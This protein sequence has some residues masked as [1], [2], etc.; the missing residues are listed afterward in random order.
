MTAERTVGVHLIANVYNVSPTLLEKMEIGV[1]L[2][3]RIIAELQLNVVSKTGYQFQPMG[4]TYA[5]VL[6]ESHFTIHTYPEYG[7]CFIDIFCCNRNFDSVKAVELLKEC[8]GTAHVVYQ[9][10]VR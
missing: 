6:S 3:E 7:S 8:F 5:F 4:Y 10:I 1:P 9:M 2:L